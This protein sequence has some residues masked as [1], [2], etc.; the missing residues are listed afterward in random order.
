MKHFKFWALLMAP[1]LILSA[2]KKS[3]D[4]P[5]LAPGMSFKI[6]GKFIKSSYC[7]TKLIW[8]FFYFLI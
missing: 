4:A 6:N 2:C 5:A 8:V 1:I 3:N 7:L